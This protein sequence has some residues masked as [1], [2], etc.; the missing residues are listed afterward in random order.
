M[1]KFW[2]TMISFAYDERVFAS[3]YSNALRESKTQCVCGSVGGQWGFCSI[4]GGYRQTTVNT[5]LACIQAG[6]T[7]ATVFGG[8]VSQLI[9]GS[10]TSYKYFLLV[11]SYVLY[12]ETVRAYYHGL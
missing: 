5:V 2:K 12:S 10:R 8:R 9:S 1:S 3:E 6:W 4:A 11:Y 7:E